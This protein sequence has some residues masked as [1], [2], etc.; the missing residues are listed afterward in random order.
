ME[1]DGDGRDIFGHEFVERRFALPQGKAVCVAWVEA[2]LEIDCM[3]GDVE[4]HSS[5][6]A[7]R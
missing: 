7:G 5:S 2:H 3:T 4:V 1:D 6:E